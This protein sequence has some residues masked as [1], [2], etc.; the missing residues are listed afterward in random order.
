MGARQ[1]A[2]VLLRG[3][4]EQAT[5]KVNLYFQ[6]PSGCRL[7]YPCIVYSMSRIR[8]EH[9]NDGVYIQH[10]FYTVTV[11]DPDPDSKLVAAVS[12]LPK[13]ACDRQF[14]SDNLYHTVFTLY[15]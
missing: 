7:N 9:A 10:P 12:V 13:C 2:D 11:I 1:K 8:N 14:V 3:V 6:P 4:L 5:G 15:I